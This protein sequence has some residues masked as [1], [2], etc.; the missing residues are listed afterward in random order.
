MTAEL[1]ALCQD[2]DVFCL[3][4]HIPDSL[5]AH[6]VLIGKASPY[7]VAVCSDEKMIHC[8]YKAVLIAMNNGIDPTSGRRFSVP[9]HGPERSDCSVQVRV[10]AVHPGDHRRRA[11]ESEGDAAAAVQGGEQG[12]AGDDHP[13]LL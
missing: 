4:C 12:E 1:L 11:A 10:Q 13:Y 2:H 5:G 7:G 3:A 6:L 8:F 9:C